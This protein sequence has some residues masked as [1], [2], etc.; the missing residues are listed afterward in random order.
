M[1]EVNKIRGCIKLVKILPIDKMEDNITAI[2][3]LIYDEDELLNEFLQKV[4]IRTEVCNED[5]DFLKCEYNRD[6]DSYR[7]PVSNKYFPSI[8]DG[9]YPSPV[10]RELE[11]KLNKMFA[12]Y[13]KAYYSLTTLTS[14][15][16]WDLADRIED[17]FAVA[18][19][20]KN[21]VNHEKE[22]N[23]G[24]WESN[25]VLNVSFSENENNKIQAVYKLTSTV[26][27]QMSFNHKVCGKVTLSG[28][29]SRQVKLY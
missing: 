15:Y 16:C 4:D 8:S 5:G 22:V 2:S 1:E 9:R 23:V 11:I 19:L 28:T 29:I 6:G 3:N 27:L 14:V 21:N 20:I 18:V 25:N 13:T 26:V 10:L 17:G 12:L 24:Q 7:S